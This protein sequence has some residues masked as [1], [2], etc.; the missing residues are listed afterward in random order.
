MVAAT[1]STPKAINA[2]MVELA[3]IIF[4]SFCG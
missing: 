3:S 2:A 4:W 1:P